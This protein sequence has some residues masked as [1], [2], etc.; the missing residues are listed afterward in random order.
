MSLYCTCI[1]APDQEKVEALVDKGGNTS[2]ALS[3]ILDTAYNLEFNERTST[4]AVRIFVERIKQAFQ[5]GAD[6][7][8][9]VLV[10]KRL[11][12]VHTVD[13][14]ICEPIWDRP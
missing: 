14:L 7:F 1:V 12:I 4:S 11:H 13:T 5:V 2:K 10:G 6:S 8:V 9:C 3:Q